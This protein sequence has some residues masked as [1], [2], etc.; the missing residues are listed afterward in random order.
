M[1]VQ[2]A[3]DTTEVEGAVRVMIGIAPER[4]GGRRRLG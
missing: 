2:M 3:M 4:Y 1:D